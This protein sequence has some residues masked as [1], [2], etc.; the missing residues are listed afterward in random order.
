[1]I[2]NTL[3]RTPVRL[4]STMVFEGRLTYGAQQAQ[5]AWAVNNTAAAVASK[6]AAKPAALKVKPA[7][8]AKKEVC[9]TS[10]QIADYKYFA[11]SKTPATQRNR[12]KSSLTH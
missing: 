2:A 3:Q 8:K 6:P 7:S 9:E 11:R 1:M 5:M 10:M 4:I 12:G